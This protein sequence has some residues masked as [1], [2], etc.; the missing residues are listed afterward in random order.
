MI[1]GNG[2]FHGGRLPRT[3]RSGIGSASPRRSS[4]DFL[5]RKHLWIDISQG[6]KTIP[7]WAKKDMQF[8]ATDSCPPYMVPVLWNTPA[9]LPTSFPFC[10]SPPVASMMVFIWAGIPPNRSETPYMIPP[11]PPNS[12][13][14]A[15]V[16]SLCQQWHKAF[17]KSFEMMIIQPQLMCFSVAMQSANHLETSRQSMMFR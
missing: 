11:K 12:F 1:L 6:N 2:Q 7:W 15:G 10:Q 5:I 14:F 9:V 3:I 17:P 16:N 8:I 4:M 13:T